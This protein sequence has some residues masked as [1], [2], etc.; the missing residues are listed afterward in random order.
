M[1]NVVLF[2]K[3]IES[4]IKS[5]KWFNSN[6]EIYNRGD[7][8]QLYKKNWYNDNQ[9]GIHF[10]TY[11]ESYQIK[12]KKFP[13]CMHV[14]NDCPSQ[15]K[16]IKMF[17]DI[18]SKRIKSWKGYETKGS[19]YNICNKYINLNCKNLENIIIE[20]FNRLQSFEETIDKILEKL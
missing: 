10:E 8:F 11:I 9:N 7:Y 13:I 17:L 5:L 20:E 6:W 16:F 19:I 12:Q 14:E 18:E 2:F 4:K 1:K 15:L 3:N